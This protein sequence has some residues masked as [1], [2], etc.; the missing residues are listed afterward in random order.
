MILMT[1]TNKYGKLKEAK[2]SYQSGGHVLHLVE[3][4]YELWR[5]AME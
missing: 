5:Y 1:P 3:E 4:H 2:Q